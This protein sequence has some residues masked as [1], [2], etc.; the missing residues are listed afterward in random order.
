MEGHSEGGLEHSTWLHFLY[1]KHILPDWLPEMVPITW[2]VIIILSLTV[3]L[4]SRGLRVRNPGRFQTFLEFAVSALDNFVRGMVGKEARTL[5]PVIGT[6]FIYI[7]SLNL[8]GLIPGFTSPTANFNTTL[9]F[10]L[11]AI[12]IVQYFG[13]TRLGPIGYIKH[14][15][16]EPIWLA[17]M[18]FPIHIIGELA[19]PLSLSIRLFGNIFGEETVIAVLI[20]ITIKVILAKVGFLYLP[21]QF[22]M[23]LLAI[24][25][26]CIQALIFSMLTGIYISVAIT[27]HEKEH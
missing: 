21:L 19:K 8:F 11:T 4:A 7:L 6:F 24:F 18:M 9:A 13:I 25:G 1:T 15:L 26:A 5:T 16:G 12:I 17:P 23:M 2:L 27:D 14:F 10:A 20:L 22:P 3:V